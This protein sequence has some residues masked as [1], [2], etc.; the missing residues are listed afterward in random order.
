MKK[1]QIFF[2]YI[3]SIRYCEMMTIIE[4]IRFNLF[5]HLLNAFAN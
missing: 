4:L 5:D 2:L 3:F 1:S